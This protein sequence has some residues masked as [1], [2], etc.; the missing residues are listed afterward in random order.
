MQSMN[1]TEAT[2]TNFFGEMA[3]EITVG[4]LIRMQSGVG[5]FDVP[6]LDNNILTDPR[7]QTP[8]DILWYIRDHFTDEMSCADKEALAYSLSPSLPYLL[9]WPLACPSVR[10]RRVVRRRVAV[11]SVQV[12]SARCSNPLVVP[13]LSVALPS[14]S[15]RAAPVCAPRDG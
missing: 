6:G 1:G 15:W 11:A 14:T 12:R 8:F 13:Y 9:P 10:C 4:Q 7:P 3:A 5:D 2:L